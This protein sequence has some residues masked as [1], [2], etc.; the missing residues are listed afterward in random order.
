MTERALSVAAPEAVLSKM[1]Q[2]GA[3]RAASE[4]FWVNGSKKSSA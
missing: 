2:V 3:E 4:S 1:H